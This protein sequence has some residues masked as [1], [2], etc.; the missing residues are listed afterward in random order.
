M[1][2]FLLLAV[3][4]ASWAS[5]TGSAADDHEFAFRYFLAT[6]LVLVTVV[7]SLLFAVLGSTHSIFQSIPL[8]MLWTLKNILFINTPLI[9][10]SWILEIVMILL[11]TVGLIMFGVG[12]YFL[13]VFLRKHVSSR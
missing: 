6:F 8:A 2:A 5:A 4:P 7:S 3:R 9:A 10:G 1:E 13:Q 11:H 12:F